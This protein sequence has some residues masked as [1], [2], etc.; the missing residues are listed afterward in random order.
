MLGFARNRRIVFKQN[1]REPMQENLF[2]KITPETHPKLWTIYMAHTEILYVFE[3]IQEDRE[4]S[5]GIA[6]KDYPPAM[7]QIYIKE[8]F[9]PVL[10]ENKIIE[11]DT[12]R[13][14]GF[15]PCFDNLHFTG[16]K[17]KQDL[18]RMAKNHAASIADQISADENSKDFC[19][20]FVSSRK[21]QDEG[22]EFFEELKLLLKKH[23][24]TKDE[25]SSQ[26]DTR[27]WRLAIIGKVFES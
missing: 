21:S 27:K 16:W 12:N 17:N 22:R 6:P 10:L 15:K 11:E 25:S 19:L 23:L 18:A 26:P 14:S 7:L 1:R 5:S 24:N 13:K 3:N 2:L 8:L 4:L 20:A 9:L